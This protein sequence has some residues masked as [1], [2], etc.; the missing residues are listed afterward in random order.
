MERERHLQQAI[1]FTC[2]RNK[3]ETG[4][5]PLHWQHLLLSPVTAVAAEGTSLKLV[6]CLTLDGWSKMRWITP[7]SLE[8]ELQRW[9]WTCYVINCPAGRE[10]AIPFGNHVFSHSVVIKRSRQLH[11]WVDMIWTEQS[12]PAQTSAKRGSDTVDDQTFSSHQLFK[13]SVYLCVAAKR[14]LQFPNTGISCSWLVYYRDL[15]MLSC[16]PYF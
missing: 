6:P 9:C 11:F 12:L 2:L 8:Y 10:L 15:C 3:P 14:L 5:E 1:N 7:L 13:G 16:I 4:H